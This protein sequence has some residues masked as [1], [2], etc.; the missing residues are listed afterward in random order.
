MSNE[1]P[2]LQHVPLTG[3]RRALVTSENNQQAKLTALESI[4]R[5]EETPCCC[6]AL[7]NVV[8]HRLERRSRVV[9]PQ[10]EA[11]LHSRVPLLFPLE[12]SDPYTPV[13]LPQRHM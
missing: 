5:T 1:K 4:K 6:Q 8:P 12:P 2:V 9:V 13:V 10:P 3:R 11:R 7:C